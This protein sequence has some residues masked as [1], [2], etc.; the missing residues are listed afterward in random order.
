MKLVPSKALN[1]RLLVLP[2]PKEEETLESGVIVAES[3]GQLLKAKVILVSDQVK[4]INQDEVVIFPEGAGIGQY[5]DGKYHLWLT[6]AQ[7]IAI[8]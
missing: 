7:V 2:Y 6:E 4:S 3:V 1:D 8:V 5:Y